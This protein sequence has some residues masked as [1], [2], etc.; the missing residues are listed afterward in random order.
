M[1]DTA[2]V[3]VKVPP[4]LL[5]EVRQ[6]KQDIDWPEEIRGFIRDRL[7]RRRAEQLLTEVHAK[8]ARLPP[9]PRGFA[10]DFVREDRDRH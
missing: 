7:R 9:R 6:S 4:S 3:S 8:H 1:S 5:E 2:V 10:A